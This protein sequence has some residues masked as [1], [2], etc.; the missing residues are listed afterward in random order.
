MNRCSV[1]SKQKA[2]LTLRF[3]K[4]LPRSKFYYCAEDLDKEPRYIVILIGRQN[5]NAVRPYLKDH[6]YEGKTI[7]ESDLS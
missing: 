6:L 3:S 2:N 4:L 5:I 7:T 1:C